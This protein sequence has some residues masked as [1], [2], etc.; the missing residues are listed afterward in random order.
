MFPHIYFTFNLTRV[1]SL[2]QRDPFSLS[3]PQVLWWWWMIFLSV[4]LGNFTKTVVKIVLQLIYWSKTFKELDWVSQVK[5][6]FAWIHYGKT[7]ISSSTI[8]SDFLRCMMM[9]NSDRISDRR[10]DHYCTQIPENSYE[11]F[12]KSRKH[13]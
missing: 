5:S 6:F 13:A 8:K 4:L 12:D 7:I 9:T 1:V 10:I 3:L 2:L 11:L